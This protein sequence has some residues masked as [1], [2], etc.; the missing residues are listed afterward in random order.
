MSRKVKIGREI[1]HE[2]GEAFTC[3]CHTPEEHRERLLK[4]LKM[5]LALM[6]ASK[7]EFLKEM[8]AAA[9][10]APEGSVLGVGIDYAK[11]PGALTSTMDD[12]IAMW[13]AGKRVQLS[14][15]LINLAALAFSMVEHNAG[16][17][18]PNEDRLDMLQA[19]LENRQVEVEP[20]L[21]AKLEAIF[22]K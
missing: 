1:F 15:F 11:I 3:P 10:P 21:K 14:C 17:E 18:I 8:R 2:E 19:A 4:T 12:I 9:P 13:V 22:K 6:D 16:W 5:R 7:A 20:E